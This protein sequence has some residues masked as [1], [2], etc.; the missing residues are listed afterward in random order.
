[1][2]ILK[3]LSF[4]FINFIIMIFHNSLKYLDE[5]KKLKLKKRQ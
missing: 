4:K 3:N 2:N 5:A 1:M